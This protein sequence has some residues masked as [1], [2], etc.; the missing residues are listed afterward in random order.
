[1][2]I[3]DD[4]YRTV[5]LY[6]LDASG[7]LQGKRVTTQPMPNSQRIRRSDHRYEIRSHQKGFEEVMCYAHLDAAIR[8]IESLGYRGKRALFKNPLRVHPRSHRQDNSWYSPHEKLI[9]MGTG[10]ID[11]A[12]DGE[13][14]LHE[15]GHALQDAIVPDFGQSEQAAAIGEGFGDYWAGSSFAERKPTELRSY[16]MSWDGLPSSLEAR[17]L[18]PYVRRLD[19]DETLNDFST[20]RSEHANGSFWAALLW[21]IRQAIGREAADRLIVESHFS[22]HAFATFTLAARSLLD[23]DALLHQSKHRDLLRKLFR[24]RKIDL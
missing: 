4:C 16:L 8:Y 21:D 2:R 6:G 22:L 18:P 7:Y 20:D 10:D 13:T 12:E 15:F 19:S 23:C 14:L 11:D 1:M 24:K 9:A 17:R 5:T 3:P